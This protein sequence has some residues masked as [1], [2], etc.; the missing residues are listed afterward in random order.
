MCYH[1]DSK[2]VMPLM[3]VSEIEDIIDCWI[4]EVRS[5]QSDYEWVQLFENKGEMMGCSNSHPHC[6]IWASSF[7]PNEPRREDVQQKR[8]YEQHKRVLLHDYLEQELRV[9][10]EESRIVIQNEDWVV[11]V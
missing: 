9:P 4:S 6:Q 5:L 1:P 11:L 2:K 10:Q 3:T 8:Y 7:L